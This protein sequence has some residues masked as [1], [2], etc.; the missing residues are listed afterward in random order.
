MVWRKGPKV[1]LYLVQHARAVEKEVNGERPLSAEG[2]EDARKVAAFLKETGL[3]VG[4]LWHSGKLRAAQ[5]AESIAEGVN[6]TGKIEEK[7]GLKPN[8]NVE[9]VADELAA[10]E[11][12]TMLVGHMP[13]V[14]R[15]ASLLLTGSEEAD[16]VGFRQGAIACLEKDENG[17]WRIEWMITPEITG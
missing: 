1:R 9:A 6:A 8:D 15:L 17:K 2:K 16:I 14:G 3:S 5:T 13:F 11:G 7:E 4:R 12:S 10:D